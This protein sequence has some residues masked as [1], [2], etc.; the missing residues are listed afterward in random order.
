MKKFRCMVFGLCLCISLLAGCGKTVESASDVV[1]V[2]KNGAVIS[3]DIEEFAQDYYDAEELEEYVNS[4]VA[5]YADVHGRGA[6]K[7]QELAV[8]GDTARLQMK[9]KTASDYAG[10]NG[11]ELYHGKVIDALAAGYVFDGAFAKVEEGK[12]T[13][14]ATKQEIY[15][16]KDLKVVIIRAN[17]NV[18]VEGEICYVSC[19]NVQLT[20]ADSVAIRAGYAIETGASSAAENLTSEEAAAATEEITDT[21][22]V[23]AGK[24]AE[25]PE[26]AFETEVYTFIVY[27]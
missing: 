12:V 27:K 11:I 7:V 5:E 19:E 1:Y 10:F 16:E 15:A 13:G 18:Q 21:E 4:A 23:D 20:G 3:V 17:M 24:A 6:V 2:E 8:D 9:Y 26:G 25:E 22:F 14:A